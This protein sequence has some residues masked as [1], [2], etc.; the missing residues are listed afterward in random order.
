MDAA[1]CRNLPRSRAR[2][3]TAARLD[4][5]GAAERANGD[6][7]WS[8]SGGVRC[9]A[10][11][12]ENERTRITIAW[13]RIVGIVTVTVNHPWVRPRGSAAAKKNVLSP[14]CECAVLEQSVRQRLTNLVR[15][16]ACQV[17]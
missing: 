4:G 9:V 12:A 6:G 1:G 13:R 7:H 14:V 5:A 8:D 11:I 3:P 2:N 16:T 15:W 17:L 10:R